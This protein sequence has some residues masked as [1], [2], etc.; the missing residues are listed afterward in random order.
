MVSDVK[1]HPLALTLKKI[2]KL[3]AVD[4]C[5][6]NQLRLVL[7]AELGI[8]KRDTTTKEFNYT[9]IKPLA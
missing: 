9:F 2:Q 6:L 5:T 4:N 7:M 8:Y 3:A 1:V